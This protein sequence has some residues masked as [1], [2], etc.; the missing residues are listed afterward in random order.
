MTMN[1]PSPSQI[2][3]DQKEVLQAIYNIAWGTGEWPKF[4]NIRRPLKGQ[5]IDAG[6]V[7]EGLMPRYVRGNGSNISPQDD[8]NLRLTL[9]GFNE[10]EGGITTVIPLFLNAL[11]YFIDV[12]RTYEPINGI[13]QPTVGRSDLAKHFAPVRGLDTATNLASR[14]RLVLLEESGYWTMGASH[15]PEGQ[16]TLTIANQIS[17]YE[18]VKTIQ[19]YFEVN[20]QYASPPTITKLASNE[21]SV[22]ERISKQWWYSKLRRRF[23]ELFK[24]PTRRITEFVIGGLILA[25]LVKRIWGG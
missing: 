10:I 13:M 1:V 2:T 11:K 25:Y 21:E 19:D 16:W 22:G 9:R 7:L 8:E 20:P 5:G 17:D 4:G 6:T 24:S 18:N 14:L 23:F 3:N 15:G 12:E